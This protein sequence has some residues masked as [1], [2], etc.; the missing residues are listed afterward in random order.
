MLVPGLTEAQVESI[1]SETD[2]KALA[3]EDDKKIAITDDILDEL[4]N[5]VD[6][7]DSF[8]LHGQSSDGR[9]DSG[10]RK[11]KVNITLLF[12]HLIII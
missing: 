1:L 10:P 9:A 12:T 3:D 2:L 11:R 8:L 6:A 4:V 5:N 7:K